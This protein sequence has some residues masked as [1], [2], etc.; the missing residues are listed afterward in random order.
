MT[1]FD[2][3]RLVRHDRWEELLA[4]GLTAEEL[5]ARGVRPVHPAFRVVAIGQTPGINGGHVPWLSAEVATY[6]RFHEIAELPAEARAEQLAA[7]VPQCPPG[8]VQSLCALA[9]QFA[10]SEQMGRLSLRQLKRL[11]LRAADRPDDIGAL[12]NA[13]SDACLVSHTPTPLIRL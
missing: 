12:H 8:A 5:E 7:M 4:T 1:L 13:L 2:G 9:D 11:C 6:F 10:S 3:T